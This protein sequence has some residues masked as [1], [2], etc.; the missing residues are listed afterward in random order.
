[1]DLADRTAYSR[2]SGRFV[3][4]HERSP[5]Q[6]AVSDLGILAL[7]AL[8]DGANCGRWIPPQ[9][10]RTPEPFLTGGVGWRVSIPV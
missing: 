1:D 3:L 6:D 5:S 7:T 8:A 4:G 9:R 10:K 2:D